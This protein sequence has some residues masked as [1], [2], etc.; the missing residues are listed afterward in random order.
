MK[1]ALMRAGD[2]KLRRRNARDIARTAL[3]L[4][5][6]N[7]IKDKQKDRRTDRQMDRQTGRQTEE[8][9]RGR[10]QVNYGMI[11]RVKS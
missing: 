5:L 1:Y 2:R 4:V 3:D 7:L 10:N 9:K 8:R 11:Q 6:W